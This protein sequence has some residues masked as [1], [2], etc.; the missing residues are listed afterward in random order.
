MTGPTWTNSQGFSFHRNTKDTLIIAGLAI[1]FVIAASVSGNRQSCQDPDLP[2]NFTI[3]Y[4]FLVIAFIFLAILAYQVYVN[5]TGPRYSSA[6][7]VRGFYEPNG[8]RDP[9]FHADEPVP[10]YH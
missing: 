6:T 2:C 1:L 9:D 8:H 3:T 10:A 5:L 4:I 7:V